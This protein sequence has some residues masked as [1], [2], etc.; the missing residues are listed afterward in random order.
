MVVIDTRRLGDEQNNSDH[1][2][3]IS[4]FV[5]KVNIAALATHL[6]THIVSAFIKAHIPQK[7][8]RTLKQPP[9]LK[10]RILFPLRISLA[11]PIV[12]LIPHLIIV[13]CLLILL[14]N[15]ELLYTHTHTHIHTCKMPLFFQFTPFTPF[16][17]CK[18]QYRVSFLT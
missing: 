9:Y 16:F 12:F 11:H 8:I 13:L 7:H 6:H 2:N 18:T 1:V 14:F 3:S 15:L 17:P 5:Q 10:G 4:C